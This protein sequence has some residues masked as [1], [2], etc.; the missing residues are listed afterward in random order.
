MCNPPFHHEAGQPSPDASRDR[1]LRDRF[2]LRDWFDVGL[3]RTTARGTFTAIVRADRLKEVLGHLPETGV[4]VFPL[5]PKPIEPA[6][7]VLVQVR[8][9]SRAMSVMMPGLVLHGDDGKYTTDADAIL[10]GEKRLSLHH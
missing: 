7:R 6:K 5:W 8:R 3:K 9:G 4:T 10:R 2:R 1:A